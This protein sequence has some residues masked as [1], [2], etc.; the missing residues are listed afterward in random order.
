MIKKKNEIGQLLSLV[1][2]KI[3]KELGSENRILKNSTSTFTPSIL[4]TTN[5]KRISD[6]FK[7]YILMVKVLDRTQNLFWRLGGRVA[8]L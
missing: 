3:P 6:I 5:V 4:E 8:K 1:V 7:Y 2:H